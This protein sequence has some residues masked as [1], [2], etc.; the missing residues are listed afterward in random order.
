[1]RKEKKNEKECSNCGYEATKYYRD[2]DNTIICHE[3]YLA[4]M[5]EIMSY[6]DNS[7]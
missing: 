1:M 7:D 4:L 2:N 3:C 5:L 6:A